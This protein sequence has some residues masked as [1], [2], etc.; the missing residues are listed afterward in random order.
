V[1]RDWGLARS[2]EP[3]PTIIGGGREDVAPPV[4]H[5][6]P[7]SGLLPGYGRMEVTPPE[8]KPQQAESFRRTWS[9]QSPPPQIQPPVNPPTIIVAP[10]SDMQG[11]GDGGGRK[12]F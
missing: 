11:R 9:A 8:S 7:S 4:G 3:Q 1:E 10:P 5:Y 12:N 6:F 2:V